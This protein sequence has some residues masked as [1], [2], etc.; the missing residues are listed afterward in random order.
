MHR[1]QSMEVCVSDRKS[2]CFW[3][4]KY[5]NLFLPRIYYYILYS[6]VAYRIHPPWAD[7]ENCR[8]NIFFHKS[9]NRR[10]WTYYRDKMNSHNVRYCC[11]FRV[12][13]KLYG[14]F[15]GKSDGRPN[16]LGLLFHPHLGS[17]VCILARK[18][19]MWHNWFLNYFSNDHRLL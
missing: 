12:I 13:R 4:S 7:G 1:I 18:G 3:Y 17:P 10:S 9:N 5:F 8:F 2:N 16:S 6:I 19:S 11:E 15:F 14:T